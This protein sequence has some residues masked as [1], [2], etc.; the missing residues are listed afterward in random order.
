MI[1]LVAATL[2]SM[3]AMKGDAMDNARKAFN[4]CMIETHNT[5][6]GEKASPSDFIKTSDAACP[7][8]RAAY[9]EILI[10]SERSYGSSMADAEKFA[11]EEIQMIVDS[12][13]TSFNEN[14]ENGAK[15]TPEK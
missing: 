15:L 2:L 14:V 8:E 5:A 1:S 6:V 9:K 4:N 7:T 11:A 13:V 3:A 12:I 10:K